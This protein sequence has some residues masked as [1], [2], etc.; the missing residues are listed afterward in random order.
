MLEDEIEDFEFQLNSLIE[1]YPQLLFKSLF[2][3]VYSHFERY[4]IDLCNAVRESESLSLKPKDLGDKGIRRSQA[5]LKKVA[6]LNFPA[7]TK[8]WQVIK[9]VTEIRNKLVHNPEHDF[10]QDEVDPKLLDYFWLDDPSWDDFDVQSEDFMFSLGSIKNLANTFV[11][12]S[13]DIDKAWEEN[14]NLRKKFQQGPK[15]K[16]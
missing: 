3:A 6:G 13:T 16:K 14:N 11:R 4:L 8:E 12:F 2:M 9:L 15:H 10:R 5:Y 7:N 1:N